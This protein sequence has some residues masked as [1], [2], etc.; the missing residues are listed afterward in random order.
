[1]N[2][3]LKVL[4]SI[5]LL[6]FIFLLVVF[7]LRVLGFHLVSDIVV[8]GQDVVIAEDVDRLVD[9]TLNLNSTKE[10]RDEKDAS[11]EFI[12]SYIDFIYDMA[13]LGN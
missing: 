8:K 3:F 13:E 10:D 2:T 11:K 6:L 4:L 5:I 1:M 7:T 9:S 12:H